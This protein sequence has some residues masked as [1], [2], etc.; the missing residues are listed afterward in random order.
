MD[1]WVGGRLSERGKHRGQ[2]VCPGHRL[3]HQHADCE[4]HEHPTAVR[5][6]AGVR[7][8][9]RGGACGS[10]GFWRR[11]RRWRRWWRWRQRVAAR[12][13]RS[14]TQCDITPRGGHDDRRLPGLGDKRIQVS[15]RAFRG[16]HRVDDVQYHETRGLGRERRAS[17]RRADTAGVERRGVRDDRAHQRQWDAAA[18]L[19]RQHEGQELR[20]PQ[21]DL[22][23]RADQVLG[24][25]RRRGRHGREVRSDL[26]HP[27]PTQF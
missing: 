1:D 26:V 10:S 14:R 19:Q 22:G 4:R 12:H 7:S 17:S 27:R 3:L 21:H 25:F 2:R 11:W 15:A 13:A 6:R 24:R 8:E 9:C 18:V 23:V 20:V 16:I 5:D